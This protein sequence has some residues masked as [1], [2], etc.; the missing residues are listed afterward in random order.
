MMQQ[1]IN[2]KWRIW[3]YLGLSTIVLLPVTSNGQDVLPGQAL[4]T[5]YCEVCHGVKGDGNGPG[6]AEFVL[7]PRDF[8]LAAFKFDTDAD[9][10][11]G[12][13]ADLAN[14]IRKGTAVYGGSAVMPGWNQFSNDEINQLV[15]YIKSLRH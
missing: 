9:W 12:T 5:T 4:F 8:A 14:V 11:K 2:F 1:Q 15:T 6:S 3:W 10:R 13:D 7:K